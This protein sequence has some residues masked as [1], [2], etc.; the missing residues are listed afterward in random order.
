MRDK[1]PAP[2]M[3]PC[4]T[5]ASILYIIKGTIEGDSSPWMNPSM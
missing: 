2:P 5:P 1:L 4:S 3:Y